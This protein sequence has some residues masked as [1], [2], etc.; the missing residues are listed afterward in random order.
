MLPKFEGLISHILPPS[1]TQ[2][3]EKHRNMVSTY[4]MV[5]PE[6]EDGS[7]LLPSSL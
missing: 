3:P 4:V 5:N 2:K 6:R 7:E 1:Q